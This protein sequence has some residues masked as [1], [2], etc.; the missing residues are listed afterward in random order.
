MPV[1]LPGGWRRKTGLP[2]L[3]L[4]LPLLLLLLLL[5]LLRLLLLRL[6]RLILIT[7][8]SGCFRLALCATKLSRV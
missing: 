1:P 8:L 2:P 3:S 7:P 5:L 4:P 6:P